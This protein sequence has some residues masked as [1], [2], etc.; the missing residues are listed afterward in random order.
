MFRKDYRELEVMLLII[1]EIEEY[2]SE[3]DS[4][5]DLLND[6]KTTDAILLQFVNLGEYV[7]RLSPEFK[8][9]FD[10]IRWVD[11]KTMRNRIAHNYFGFNYDVL[12]NVLETH[13]LKLKDDIQLILKKR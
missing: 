11:I 9:V 10:E 1:N 5:D 8:E 6:K 13:L 4:L 3:F 2:A 7:S 12:K